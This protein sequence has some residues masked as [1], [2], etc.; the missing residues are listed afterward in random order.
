MAVMT[1][2]SARSLVSNSTD[3]S[4]VLETVVGRM[5]ELVVRSVEGIRER[6]SRPAVH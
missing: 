2:P 5:L 6:I 4:R 3:Q 1:R